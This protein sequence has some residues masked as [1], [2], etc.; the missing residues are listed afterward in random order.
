VEISRALWLADQHWNQSTAAVLAEFK[1]GFRYRDHSLKDVVDDVPSLPEHNH[2]EKLAFP[3]LL[4]K[5]SI[6]GSRC[7]QCYD[8]TISLPGP[9][10]FLSPLRPVITEL[11]SS[12]FRSWAD[13]NEVE[14]TNMI[15][16]LVLAWSYIL[17]ARLWELQGDSDVSV[18]YTE[19]KAPILRNI[20][21]RCFP[22]MLHGAD[23]R[24]L[25]WLAAILAPE[26]GFRSK[27]NNTNCSPWSLRLSE[28]T[29]PFLIVLCDG[30]KYDETGTY[31]ALTSSE[32][33]RCLQELCIQYCVGRGQIHTSL[34]IALLIPLHRQEFLDVTLPA[35][36]ET[37]SRT[38]AKHSPENDISI[39]YTRLPNFIT[40][41][42]C[43]ELLNSVLCSLFWHAEITSNVVSAWLQPLF[44]LEEMNGIKGVPGRYME[45]VALL[46]SRNTPKM[47]GLSV[48]AAISGLLST[49]LNQVREVRSPL[50]RHA[51]AWTGVPQSFM[52]VGDGPYVFSKETQSYIRRAD[53]WRLR[54]LPPA[55]D[56]DLTYNRPPF[57]PWEPP[58]AS[59]LTNCPLRV[60]VHQAC[61][62]HSWLYTGCVW[63][64][65][66]G[67]TIEEKSSRNM[68]SRELKLHMEMGNETSVSHSLV[69]R[70]DQI[71]A[72]AT[73]TVFRWVLDNGDGAPPEQ[74]YKDP[75]IED[76]VNGYS[77]SS[78]A[79]TDRDDNAES[80]GSAMT[81][82]DQAKG[83]VESWIQDLDDSTHV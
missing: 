57:S 28:K 45:V 25:R 69:L 55:V 62:R 37:L 15:S 53:C 7:C 49:V 63:H 14:E 41:S 66:N 11:N 81:I 67:R 35:P 60:Q 38:V 8:K 42:T 80:A 61:N 34:A 22:V 4:S 40:L 9:I 65:E 72:I 52:E 74:V 3:P 56:D 68:I 2:V 71:S 20:S 26:L 6:T 54:L 73:K 50:E 78:D 10:P 58:G 19:I 12:C 32:A 48:G 64:F 82:S 70:D 46:C 39:M 79:A 18:S 33:T 31:P 21:S 23:S 29:P 1:N 77:S 13:S 30:Q 44:D 47:T 24:T 59:L 5:W 83:M 76:L 51:Y 17:S 43:T 16:V 27:R 75:W 36:P